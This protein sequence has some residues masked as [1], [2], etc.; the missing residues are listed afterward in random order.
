MATEISPLDEDKMLKEAISNTEAELFR[1]ATDLAD[2]QE[3][4]GEADRSQEE[5]GDGLEGQVDKSD[6]DD[7]TDGEKA[8]GEE[9]EGDEPEAEGDEAERD[10]KGQFKAKEPE[11]AK[12]EQPKGRVPVAELLTERKARQAAEDALKTERES[13]KAALDAMNARLDNILLSQQR[14]QEKPAEPVKSEKPDQFAEPEKWEQWLRNDISQAFNRQRIESSLADAHDQHGDEFVKAY[15]NLIGINIKNAADRSVQVNLND[16]VVMAATERIRN[17][18]NPG[19]AVMQWNAQQQVLREVGPDPAKYRET[20]EKQA[21]E[22]L[23]ADPEFRKEVFA[24]LKG[25]A[26][27]ANGGPPRNVVRIP[28]SLSDVAGGSSAN[29]HDGQN[30]SDSDADVFADTWKTG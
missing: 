28:K 27:G 20:I 12:E 26:S 16:P 21:R 15:Q 8:D 29:R 6:E 9:A 14:T 4:D 2:P 17:S 11:V 30:L 19:R 7:E 25:E 10:D 22:K 3:S 5:M 23:M 13:S 1:G 24:K 18:P